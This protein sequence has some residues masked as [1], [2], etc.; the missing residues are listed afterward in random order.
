MLDLLIKNGKVVDGTGCPAYRADLAIQ[1]GRILE[2]SASI[3]A[4]AR[5]T[6][7]AE[8]LVASPGFIDMHSHSDFT[9]L[10]HPQA[11]SKIRQGV[12]T[13]VVGNCGGSPAPVP[14]AHFDDFMDY[15]TGLGGFYKRVLKPE[16]WKWKTLSGFWGELGKGGLA[17]NVVPMVGHSTL[18]CHVMGYESREPDPAE[19]F[20]MKKLLETELEAGIF[21]LSTGLIYHPGAFA[22]REELAEL[23]KVVKSFDG[24]YSS[25]MRSEGK[26]LFEAVEE[27]LW[28]AAQS[29]AS[30]Q[31][32]HLKCETP[33]RWGTA[34]RLLGMIERAR[35]DGLRVHFDQY[36]Y[37]AYH[38]ALLEIFPVADKENGPEHMTRILRDETLRSGVMEKMEN[39]PR[40][41]DN[42]MEGLDWG[43]VRLIGFTRKSYREFEGMTVEEI[44]RKLALSPLEAVFRVFAEENGTLG[45]IVFSMCEEDIC[46][47]MKSP[48]GMIGSD[49]SSVAPS[50]PTAFK[51][52]HPRY[53]GTFPRVLGRYVREKKVLS[54]EEAVRKMTGLPAEKLRLKDRGLLKEGSIADIVLFDAEKVADTSE[55]TCPHRFPLG[56]PY[57]YVNG[58]AVISRGEHTGL[59]PGKVLNRN[60]DTIR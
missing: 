8:N 37:T 30:T 48:F 49:G 19:L 14:D 43:K 23:A 28:V 54:L 57:V 7:S 60:S 31:I 16:D 6:L 26:F 38:C 29:G 47:I 18:R 2:I 21:G 3:E 51:S 12:T 56:I 40:D 35:E 9:L 20:C 27:A 46:D 53:Y 44:A 45:M 59:L 55:F 25:H 50:G 15:A 4:P 36:P 52:V 17:V 41:W 5:E 11:E 22:R 34:S 13:E 1:D 39:P 58:R 32:S 42:P 33:V 24:V 10:L